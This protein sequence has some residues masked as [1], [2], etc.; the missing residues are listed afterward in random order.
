[1]N[2][3]LQVTDTDTALAGACD[4][5]AET[6]ADASDL[7][8][9]MQQRVQRGKIV[10]AVKRG[11]K[12]DGERF[13]M[14]FDHSE[15]VER[16]PSHRFLAM[17]RGEAEGILRVTIDPDEDY[18]M[19]RLQQRLLQNPALNSPTLSR[20]QSPI[21]IGDCFSPPPNRR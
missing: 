8:Q 19:P 17:K 20:R 5:V 1:M 12:T 18:V 16:V 21:V 14:Y 4:I 11:R 10:A 15:R 3:K 13:A 2:P 6:W 9:W 7:R